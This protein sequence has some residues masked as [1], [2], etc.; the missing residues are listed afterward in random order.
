MKYQEIPMYIYISLLDDR[1]NFVRDKFGWG[2]SATDSL[3]P[4]LIEYIEE[5]GVPAEN[6]DPKYIVDN[7][8]VNGNFISREDFDADPDSYLYYGNTWQDICDNALIYN[9]EYAC[10]QF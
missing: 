10:M 7:Y 2:D 5:L 8:C 9:D 6:A 4:A 3:W 1:Y